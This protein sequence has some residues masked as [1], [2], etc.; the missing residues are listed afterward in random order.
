MAR[1]HAEEGARVEVRER[2]SAQVGVDQIELT[3]IDVRRSLLTTWP[4]RQSPTR[5]RI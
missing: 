1:L 5:R 3:Q 2:R 4:V